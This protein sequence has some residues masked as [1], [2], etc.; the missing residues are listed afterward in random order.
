[1]TSHEGPTLLRR[2]LTALG[3]ALKRGILGRSSRAYMK[4]FNGGDEYWERALTAQPQEK[5]G[6]NA[7]NMARTREPEYEPVHA[8]TARQRD[9]Y[10]RRNPSYRPAYEAA[11]LLRGKVRASSVPPPRST[12]SSVPGGRVVA[13]PGAV[14]VSLRSLTERQ[15]L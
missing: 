7:G 1:M 11:L 13:A 9:D 5:P 14:A 15:A 10:L 12:Q 3:G 4:Q 2:L 6:P 8:W